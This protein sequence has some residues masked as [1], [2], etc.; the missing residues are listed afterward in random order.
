MKTIAITGAEGF[1][2]NQFVKYLISNREVFIYCLVKRGIKY[3]HIPI[4]KNIKVIQFELSEADD[5][6]DLLP[7]AVDVLYHFAWEGVN[8][9]YR[10]NFDVQVKNINYTLKILEM[11]QKIECKKVVFLGSAAEFAC[12]NGI[13]S[14]ASIPN[15]SDAYSACK[16]A[17][18]YIAK[19]Y[20]E[21]NGISAIW[22]ILTSIY[23][24][25]RDDNN[26]LSYT[27]KKLLNNEIPCVTNLEQKWDYLHIDDLVVALKEIGEKGINGKE[28]FVGSGQVKTLLEYVTEIRNMIN[29][30][31][32]INIGAL[33]YKR[34]RIDHSVVDISDLLH[35][36]EYT[37]RIS[38]REGIVDVINYY[39]S[40]KGI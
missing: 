3:D 14:S 13:I 8:A 28:Y 19:V 21:K 18:R 11:A 26:L 16:I 7:N 32:E 20:S 23:G 9:S 37:S 39:K 27:I 29:P 38:F 34:G 40:L 22:A 33:P 2:G 15:P 12:S 10:Y 30:L 35:D 6:C 36:T 4:N 5:L 1:I 17:S 25:G 24:A 31:A